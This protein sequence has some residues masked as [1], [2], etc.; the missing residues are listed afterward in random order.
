MGQIGEI[1]ERQRGLKVRLAELVRM[2][3]P[4]SG[5]GLAWFTPVRE[6]VRRDEPL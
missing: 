5:K 3:E 6:P 1:L 2:A 4:A